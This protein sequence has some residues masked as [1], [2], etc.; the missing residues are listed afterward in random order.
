ML[1]FSLGPVS[2]QLNSLSMGFCTLLKAYFLWNLGRLTWIFWFPIQILSSSLSSRYWFCTPEK[3]T[4]PYCL[5]WQ[6]FLFSRN[7]SLTISC[8]SKIFLNCSTLKPS[9]KHVLLYLHLLTVFPYTLFA[10]FL[11]LLIVIPCSPPSPSFSLSISIT[12]IST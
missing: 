4:K 8:L 5:P 2:V 10:F 9:A 6:F 7:T 1:V 12:T 3:Q 11:P